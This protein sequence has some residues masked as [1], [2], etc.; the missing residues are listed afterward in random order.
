VREA[1][2]KVD[3]VVDVDDT[4]HQPSDR[5]RFSI[6]QENLEFYGVD[7][8]AVYDTIAAIIGG[9]RSATRSAAMAQSRSRL[10]SN[11]R[12]APSGWASAFSRRLCPLEAPH[13]GQEC[14]AR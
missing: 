2:Q 10:T 6:N 9:V 13:A 8:Q 7:E 3:F 1:F 5:L 12:S 4:F 14:G 11:Y